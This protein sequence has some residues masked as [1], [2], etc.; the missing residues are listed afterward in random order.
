MSMDL[1][2]G[3]D[4]G[5]TAV[6]A[7]LLSVAGEPIA[8]AS[9][10]YGLITPHE[11]WVEQDPK[12]LWLGV[13]STC[14]SVM[15]HVKRE[16]KLIAL[17][18][19]S[20]AGTTIPVDVEGEPI[21]N[22][23]SWM[24]NRSHHQHKQVYDRI[25]GDKI[26][27]KS[28][29]QLGDGLPLLHIIWMRQNKPEKFSSVRW[30]LFVN[31]FII[32]KLT[33]Q[34]CM[35]PSDAGITQLYNI[36]E[37][38]W[39]EEMLELAGINAGQLSP[40]RDSGFV[41]GHITPQAGD[42]TG[43]PKSVLVVNGAHDQY[44]GA[45]GAGVSKPGDVMLSCGTAWVILCAM[46]T[47]KLD[48]KGRLSISRS[49]IPGKWG[50]LRSLG[51]VGACMEWFLR[52]LWNS[53]DENHSLYEELNK[54]VNKSPIGS[55]GLIFIPSSGG[56]SRGARGGFIGLG[57]SHSRGD[58]ARAI[59]E[60]ITFELR[61]IMEDI[62]A[63]GIEINE[64]KMVSGAAAS[65]VWRQIVSDITNLTVIIPS[66]REAASFGAAILAGVG[67]G[68]FRDADAGYKML[69]GDK[70]FLEP[71]E[72]DSEKYDNLFAIYKTTFEK[73]KDSLSV[74]SKF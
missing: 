36:A 12:E 15:E 47:M 53:V 23:I 27:K 37:G 3:L 11:D 70:I 66:A 68:V 28:G 40:L 55:K 43:L 20:Q 41:I 10:S 50:A 34:F 4:V 64:M 48:P 69:A 57:L 56:Y 29:W 44:C 62:R 18:I 14:R 73:I 59:M 60:G 45:L 49:A 65:P 33:G 21:G 46:D 61:W 5:T 2:L 24:D 35:N 17:S 72:K 31:D 52:N 22:A 63:A 6:K 8:S 1:L 58:M 71:D 42:E 25:G 19:S 9:Y 13:V 26:Y 74:L 7:L 16:D 54:S 39:D 67:S 51:G 32:Y 38:W 30:F